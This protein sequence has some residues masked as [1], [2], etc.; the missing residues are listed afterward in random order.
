MGVATQVFQARVSQEKWPACETGINAALKPLERGFMAIQ[1]GKNAGN[2]IIG[3]MSVTE[4]FRV[5][6]RQAHALQRQ[7]GFSRRCMHHALKAGK[8]GFLLH[9]A[10]GLI[11]QSRGL[12]PFAN[13]DRE[14]QGKMNGVLILRT[15]QTPTSQL[16]PGEFVLSV[17]EVDLRNT[18]AGGLFRIERRTP[19]ESGARVLKQTNM[20]QNRSQTAVGMRQILLKGECTLQFCNRFDMLE[21]FRWSPEQKRLGYIE[22]WKRVDAQVGRAWMEE[23]SGDES[24]SYTANYEL[25]YTVDG[26]ALRVF[27]RSED[28]LLVS[29]EV[30][31]ARLA[32]H[33]PGT[34]GEIF[35]DPDNPSEARLNLGRNAVTLGWPLWLLLGG[36]S[37]L[38]IAISLWLMGTP[39]VVW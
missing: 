20:C 15:L 28:P 14:F 22:K 24:T 32:R 9:K 7:L 18:V 33:A 1:Q 11:E 39:G 5:R 16:F 38:L 6:A 2:L 29:A 34:R 37:M 21:V 36:G 27:L 30:V 25:S 4:R 8:H 3:V 31:Q 10:T 12:F 13:H 26:K 23:E 17:P 19:F 35:V